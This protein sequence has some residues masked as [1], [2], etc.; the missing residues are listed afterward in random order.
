MASPFV[1]SLVSLGA[2]AS[3]GAVVWRPAFAR[4]A[5]PQ[6]MRY[7]RHPHVANDGRI[8]FSYLGDIWIADANGGTARR[9][10]THIAHDDNPRFSPDG[11]WIAFTSNRMGNGDVFL[12]P[13]SGGEPKQLTWHTGNDDV[14][15]WTPDGKGI[16]IS[17]P[18]GPHA[19][20]SPL[21]VVPIDGA[22]PHPLPMDAG[23]AGMIKQD[24]SVLAY[25]RVLPTYWRHGYKGNATGNIYVENLK[26][27]ELVQ[28][29]NPDHKNYKTG[30][31]DVYPMWGADG[32]I[33]FAS[34]RDSIYNIWRIDADGKN[35]SQVTFHK[36]FGVQFP[37]ISPDGRTIIY[38]NEFDLWTLK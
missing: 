7:L 29:T 36:T 17:S 19:Y 22:V 32:K 13:A 24:G 12:V 5:E 37:S 1:R 27:Q 3:F 30:K 2:I 15:Y 16:V 18:R 10:T 11:Q 20:F 23:A 35:L 21:Y 9:V 14:Q 28:L 25:N 33:Y 6:P 38:E 4:R 8:T 34:E 26:S 31:N